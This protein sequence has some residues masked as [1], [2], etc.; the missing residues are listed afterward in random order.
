MFDTIWN[1]KTQPVDEQFLQA[2]E[3]FQAGSQK[4]SASFAAQNSL[5][6]TKMSPN[7][8]QKEALRNLKNK[9]RRGDKSSHHRRHWNR[10]NIFSSI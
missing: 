2:Y 7:A 1:E 10:K 6:K 8:M 9:K 4:V 5:Y 3:E